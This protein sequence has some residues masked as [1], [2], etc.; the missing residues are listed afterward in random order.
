M[1]AVESKRMVS[2]VARFEVLR[3]QILQNT[4]YL[5]ES[6]FDKVSCLV[7]NQSDKA[8]GGAAEFHSFTENGGSL[9][10]SRCQA[11]TN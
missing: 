8:L 10:F 3:I 1:N 9:T 2:R 11:S 6:I 4:L 5:T 7:G